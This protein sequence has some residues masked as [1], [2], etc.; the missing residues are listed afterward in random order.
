MLDID[1]VTPHPDGGANVFLR[2]HKTKGALSTWIDDW[3]M[4]VCSSGKASMVP[5]SSSAAGRG[6]CTLSP[7]F[8]AERSAA[9][10]TSLVPWSVAPR[11]LTS[12]GIRSCGCCFNEDVNS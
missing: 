5:G 4:S 11:H 8:G 9:V 3:R 7:M 12:F 2:M 6:D 1:R 10:S